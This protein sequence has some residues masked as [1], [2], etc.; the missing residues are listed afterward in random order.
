MIEKLIF[1]YH[2]NK[3]KVEGY[4]TYKRLELLLSLIYRVSLNNASYTTMKQNTGRFNTS[5]VVTLLE[6]LKETNYAIQVD[7]RR[8]MAF[9][10][11]LQ[12]KEYKLSDYFK[13]K[14]GIRSNETAVLPEIVKECLKFFNTIKR[15]DVNSVDYYATELKPLFRD[16][17]ELLDI[18]IKIRL[19]N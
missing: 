1:K 10:A 4:N 18:Y 9:M 17:V 8:S 6:L 19:E 12:L 16:V 15:L 3:T 7:Y 11:D 2:Y 5:N 14:E 13:T